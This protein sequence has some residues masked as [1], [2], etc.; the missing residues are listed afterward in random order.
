MEPGSSTDIRL[1]KDEIL[2]AETAGIEVP[3]SE[4]FS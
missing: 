3:L 2:R 4:L 1:V